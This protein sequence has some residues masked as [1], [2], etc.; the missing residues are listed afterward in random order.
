LTDFLLLGHSP[1]GASTPGD[2]FTNQVVEGTADADF[3]GV[4]L[5][6]LFAALKLEQLRARRR[7]RSPSGQAGAKDVRH[8]NQLLVV[9]DRARLARGASDIFCGAKQFGMRVTDV[10]VTKQSLRQL[11]QEG[12]SH[13]SELNDCAIGSASAK[14]LIHYG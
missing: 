8:F 10:F 9:A 13:Q 1:A 12:V 6:R 7:A 5:H 2:P 3:H 14:T 4:T 11:G